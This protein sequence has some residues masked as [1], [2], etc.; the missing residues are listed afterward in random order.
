MKLLMRFARKAEIAHVPL[1][2]RNRQELLDLVETS[3]KRLES[4]ELISTPPVIHISQLVRVLPPCICFLFIQVCW[5]GS[6]GEEEQQAIDG[7]GFL[8]VAYELMAIF[9]P[10][11]GSACL[12]FVQV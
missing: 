1:E 8:I 11:T 5:D 9:L 2:Q 4:A 12:N 3:W 6:D 7:L 10:R